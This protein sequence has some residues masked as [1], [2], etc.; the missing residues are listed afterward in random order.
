MATG[1]LTEPEQLALMRGW[2]DHAKF[3]AESLKI[4]S[5]TGGIVPMI[6]QPSQIKLNNAIQKQRRA[7]KPVRICYLKAGQ[8]MVSAA[9]A[10]QNFQFVPFMSGRY[11]LALAD[12]DA[13]AL[14]VFNYYKDFQRLYTPFSAGIPGA[15]VMLPDL[16]TDQEQ[17]LKWANGSAIFCATGKNV[18]VGRSHPWHAVQISEFGFQP[19]G[20]TLMDGLMQRVPNKPD[21]MVIV[22]S[23]GFG[24]GGPFYE[25]CKRTQDPITAGDWIF[26]FFGWHEH[27]EYQQEISDPVAFQRDLTRAEKDEQQKYKL[28]LKQLA[29]RRWCIAN[30]CEGKIEVFRQEFPSNPREAFQSSSRTYLDL[31]MLERCCEIEETTPGELQILDMGPERRVHFQQKAGG[32]LTIYRRPKRYGRYVIGADA[33][34][35]KDPEAKKGGRSDPDFAAA[36]VRDADT[37]EQVAV[38]H[39]RVTE[40]YF[41]KQV[42]ALGWF[43][44]WAFVVPETTGH[45]RAFLQA[46]LE[47]GYPHDAVYRKQRPPGDMRPVTF[48]ELGYETNDVTRPVLLSALDTALMQGAITIHDN[49]T[50][51]ECRTLIVNPDGRVEAKLGSHDDLAF[52]EALSIIGLR[53]CPTAPR[54]TEE[55]QRRR[56]QP[57]KYGQRQREDDD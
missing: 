45:G 37:G 24:E 38:Y 43:Y 16:L 8:V 17:S 39:D 52:A 31:G 54:L 6:L 50:A 57:V 2:V 23:T 3:A 18:H 4:R 46:L 51:Q 26:L 42:Y 27:P 28:T 12:S 35:G 19:G 13:H 32:R 47:E 5:K 33:S 29:W 30:N 41:G 15:G 53:F 40:A 10:A 22:E 49:Q 20:A 21:T 14:L 25:L 44:N 7:G 36:S 34:Q 9:T 56:W 48:N 55:Q 1:Q 11:C